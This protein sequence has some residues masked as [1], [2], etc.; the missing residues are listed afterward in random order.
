M[1][2]VTLNIGGMTCGG[3]VKSVTKVLS[4]TAGVSSTNVDLAS[5]SAVVE[6]DDA[7]T[8]IAALIDVVE[9]A[10]FDAVQA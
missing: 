3:C 8:N 1:A 9:D 2:T 7:K 5:A 10:G 4:E 6:F